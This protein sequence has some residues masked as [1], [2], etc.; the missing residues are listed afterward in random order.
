MK[1]EIQKL[2]LA[3]MPKIDKKEFILS[4]V[5][6]KRVLDLG[7]IGHTWQR[8]VTD[9][10][11]LHKSIIEVSSE[12]YGIDFLQ[13]DVQVL[14]KQGYENIHYGDAT[15]VNLGRKFDVIVVGDLIEHVHDMR[16]L[17]E[18]FSKHLDTNGEVVITTPNPFYINHFITILLTNQIAVNKEHVFWFDPKV[19]AELAI[20]FSF[21]VSH[22][23]WLVDSDSVKWSQVNKKSLK[24]ITFFILFKA[25]SFIRMLKLLRPYYSSEFGVI[26]KMNK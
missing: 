11:W 23:E 3:R 13:D 19:L 2:L 14:N 12:C 25:F 20:R 21:D 8:S 5:R 22:M 7:C 6:N 15:D 24:E 26:L 4:R 9:P 17:F 1:P 16:G 10:T 18:T